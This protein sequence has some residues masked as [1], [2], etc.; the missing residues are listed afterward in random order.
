MVSLRKG[1]IAWSLKDRAKKIRLLYSLKSFY[2]VRV[3]LL[4][5]LGSSWMSTSLKFE[6]LLCLWN[7]HYPMASSKKWI[8]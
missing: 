7:R 6:W 8:Y 4:E 1:E 2:D 3:F 5:M